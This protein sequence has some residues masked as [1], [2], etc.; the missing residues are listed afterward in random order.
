MGILSQMLSEALL[1]EGSAYAKKAIKEL[2]NEVQKSKMTS[3]KY[4]DN[5]W[6]YVHQL[7][8]VIRNTSTFVSELSYHVENGGY[9]SNGNTKDWELDITLT[10]GELIHGRISAFAAGTA[11]DPW[12]SYDMTATFW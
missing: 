10:S 4:S 8:D 6:K 1:N 2:Y 11:K 3:H 5:D 9:R 7:M 12:S